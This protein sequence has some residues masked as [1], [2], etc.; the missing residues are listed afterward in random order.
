LEIAA[1]E[2]QN[3]GEPDPQ[4]TAAKV[5]ESVDAA[6]RALTDMYNVMQFQRLENFCLV[7]LGFFNASLICS[8][9]CPNDLPPQRIS[10]YK[11][12]LELQIQGKRCWH[13]LRGKVDTLSA[14][15]EVD[16]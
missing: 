9:H 4:T 1:Q 6:D 12:R 16:I 11:E 8:R 10:P 5:E 15:H 7:S 2:L 13:V 3:S 14:S